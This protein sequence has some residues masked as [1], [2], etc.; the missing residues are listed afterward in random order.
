MIQD[1]W[2]RLQ[3]LFESALDRDPSERDSY[4]EEACGGDEEL[5]REV[6]A[7]VAC[8][9]QSSF[10]K[11]DAVTLALSAIENRAVFEPGHQ[12]GPYRIEAQ[13]AVGGMGFVYRALDT[14]LQ[15]QVAIKVLRLG[16]LGEKGRAMLKREARSIAQLQHPNICALHDIGEQDGR[17][18]LVMEYLEGET[19]ADRLKRKPL[20]L[21][22]VLEYAIQIAAA[23]EQAHKRGV[24]HRDLKPGNVIITKTAA[25]LLDFGL[26][27]LHTLSS[28]SGPDEPATEVTLTG[29]VAGTLP[30][31]APEQ[32]RGERVDART[33]IFA[34]GLVLYEML[35]GRRAF[36][37]RQRGELATAILNDTPPTLP[38]ILA[39]LER[40]LNVCLAKDPD[41][42]WQSAGD[43]KRELIW[44]GALA[45]ET[46]TPR[47]KSR[48]AIGLAAATALC[49]VAAGWAGYYMHPVPIAHATRF[50]LNPPSGA[51]YRSSVDLA[52]S[53]NGEQLVFNAVTP[54]GKSMLWIRPLN[55]L[56]AHV[57]PGT[58]EG[59]SPFWSGDSRH[60]AF[61]A[62][63]RLLTVDPAGGTIQKICD[64]PGGQTGT[65]GPNDKI[66]FSPVPLSP[67]YS[68]TASGGSPVPVT[69]F[70]STFEDVQ[71]LWPSFLPDG[72]HFL[73]SAFGSRHGG[74]LYV[75]SLDSK[76]A[77]F[78]IKSPGRAHYRSGRLYFIDNG[79]KSQP[80]D[81]KRLELTGQPTTVAESVEGGAGF[82]IAQSGTLVYRTASP[83]AREL[84]WW[85]K[86]GT[87]IS[88]PF[89]RDLIRGAAVSPDG[90]T[91]ATVLAP[92]GF[93]KI[94][95]WKLPS[96]EKTS[97]TQNAARDAYPVW[98]PDSKKLAYASDRTGHQNTFLQLMDG[99][100]SESPVSP[101]DTEKCP[102]GWSADGRYLTLTER[103]GPIFQI[104]VTPF[105]GDRKEFRFPESKFSVSMGAFSPDGKWMAYWTDEPGHAE[106]FVAS[107]PDGGVRRRVSTDGGQY[108]QWA[109]DGSELYYVNSK[110]Q[111]VAMPI[112]TTASTVGLGQPRRF[113]E[114][115]GTA[116][117][118]PYSLTDDG[119]ILA[120]FNPSATLPR[121]IVVVLN[122]A[123]SPQTL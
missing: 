97:L 33:D 103:I 101:T 44:I 22:Q 49:A 21:P 26:A 72:R 1:R 109:K 14:R 30:Y 99:S 41:D 2:H 96:L 123:A 69:A 18:F 37:Q 5:Y 12:L 27:S 29:T 54:D 114:L 35:S 66:V 91:V 115:P 116:I 28:E 53:P 107:F 3:S 43:L 45:A 34:F 23:L 105:F 36:P 79:L 40:V 15:R 113:G 4:L 87:Q 76:K 10:L 81:L 38:G 98:S 70:D 61:F 95:L 93:P 63:G 74:M 39:P 57:L 20:D 85:D 6:K 68:V 77:K 118:P 17:D 82:D 94:S 11:S 19:L 50:T 51:T 92:G 62:K 78:L 83:T 88:K 102:Y 100:G 65:W 47:R 32:I 80:F 120:V 86:S 67:L 121:P 89:G 8:N 42:R 104:W 84:V 25:K 119:R 106:I 112:S 71:H 7:L 24:I 110:R 52:L 75:G 108:P 9:A 56:E 64:A 73:F 46:P 59:R 60:L 55:E 13:I 16:L 58:E 122:V 111:L 117:G 90:K 31:M 48:I